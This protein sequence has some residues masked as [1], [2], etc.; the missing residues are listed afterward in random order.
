MKH[1]GKI[2]SAKEKG[3]VKLSP[4]SETKINQLI[5]NSKKRNTDRPLG[6]SSDSFLSTR[7]SNITRNK[8]K[9]TKSNILMS[10]LDSSDEVERKFSFLKGDT[11]A[12]L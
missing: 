7:N 5:K 10:A 4:K 2:S 8:L 1:K 12:A 6:I 11:A 3:K 9:N